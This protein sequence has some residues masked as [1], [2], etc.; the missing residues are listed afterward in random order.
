MSITIN[1]SFWYSD[2][3]TSSQTVTIPKQQSGITPS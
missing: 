1:G 2:S 3:L